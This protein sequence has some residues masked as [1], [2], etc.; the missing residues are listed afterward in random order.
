MH[1]LIGLSDGGEEEEE[2]MA[3]SSETTD[4]RGRPTCSRII[5][6]PAGRCRSSIALDFALIRHGRYR[7]R[8]LA[9]V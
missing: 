5:V 8:H 7:H 2:I 9:P 4:G 3:V 1:A 6:D